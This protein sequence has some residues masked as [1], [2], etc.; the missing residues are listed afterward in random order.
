MTSTR[1]V[2]QRTDRSGEPGACS[3]RR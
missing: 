3:K 1:S 2:R